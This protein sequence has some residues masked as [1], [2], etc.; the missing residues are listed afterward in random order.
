[1]AQ[2]LLNI[3]FNIENSM[4]SN[5]NIWGNWDACSWFCSKRLQWGVQNIKSW[6]ILEASYCMS[7]EP[8]VGTWDGKISFPLYA[9][10]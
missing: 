2:K 8:R 7:L 5:Q 1:M 4:K 6:V 3:D 10:K 9:C